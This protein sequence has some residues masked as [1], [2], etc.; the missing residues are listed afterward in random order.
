MKKFVDKH[1][2]LAKNK[3]YKKYFDRYNDNSRKQWQ[4]IN[5]LLNRK[6]KKNSTLKLHDNNG[7]LISTPPRGPRARGPRAQLRKNSMI[8]LC[9][10]LPS[11]KVT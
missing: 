1:I 9:P 7:N 5:S 8:I 6:I 2:T 11:L 3:H 4:L 10:L